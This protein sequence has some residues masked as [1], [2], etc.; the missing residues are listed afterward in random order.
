[1][2]PARAA[3]ETRLKET[4]LATDTS[5]LKATPRE[6]SGKGP[7]RQ[8]RMKGLVPPST[9]DMQAASAPKAQK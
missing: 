4:V 8:L 3:A 6:Q 2:R 7:A 1:M 5:T 9:E